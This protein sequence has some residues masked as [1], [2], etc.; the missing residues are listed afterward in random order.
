MFDQMQQPLGCFAPSPSR[1]SSCLARRQQSDELPQPNKI[2]SPT[3]PGHTLNLTQ[4]TMREM[5]QLSPPNSQY[6]LDLAAQDNSRLPDA[7][8]NLLQAGRPLMELGHEQVTRLFTRFRDEV[9]P[10]YPCINLDLGNQIISNVFSFLENTCHGI[11]LTID[12]ID[13]EVTKAVVAIALL[14]EENTQSPL[15]SD[16]ESQLVWSVDSCFDQEKTQVEDIVM[17]ILLVKFS[18]P[19]CPKLSLLTNG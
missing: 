6:G 4:D 11:M 16:L 8:I 1:R 17:A 14:L 15:A 9:Y 5:G 3:D 12:M 18:L 19:R 7:L 10:L 13:M 2:H